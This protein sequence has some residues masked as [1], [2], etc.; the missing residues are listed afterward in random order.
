MDFSRKLPI[1]VQSFK[2]L[3]DDNFL[4]IDKTEYVY[5]LA[6]SGRVYFLS[7]PRRFG[8]SLFL[9]TLK[10]YFLGQKELFK[11]LAI[12]KF[13]EAEKGKREIWQEYPVFYFDF[14][15][16]KYADT[17]AL[18]ERLDFLL[19]DIEK[20]YEI[21]PG[22]RDSLGSRFERAIKTAYEKT[23]KQVVILVDEYDKPLLQTMGL[24]EELN[25][26]YKAVLRAFYSVLKSTDQYLRF[27]FLTGV[28]KFGKV[29]IFSDLNSLND[30][31]LKPEY[32]AICGLTQKELE[33]TFRP[34]IKTLAERNELSYEDCLS[35]LKKKYDGYCFSYG[36][37]TIY[38]PFSL[39]N[40]FDG[41]QFADYWFATGTPTFLVNELKREDYNI[42]E[43]D[44]NVEMIES[45]LSD[46]RVGAD[47]VIPVL[48]QAG[49]LTIKDYDKE[50][51]MYRLGFPNE[52]VRYGFLYNLLPEYSNI[53]FIK[54]SFNVVQFT[55]DLKAGRVDEFMQ[56][57]K[58]IM[59]SLP[60]D[61]VKKESGESIAL[62]EHNFQVC[63]Y[64]IFALMGQFVEVETPSST[65][66][67][68]CVVKTEKAIY[69]FEFKLKENA[70]A[71][72][73]QI[74][75][76]NYAERYKAD[77]KEIILIGVSFDPEEGTV[78]EWLS[79]KL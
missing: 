52:E 3:R 34:E 46:Y 20:Q 12:E 10:A 22:S 8:K 2:V 73:K 19:K 60:Y 13:E 4:Y 5:R 58:S 47:S 78:D 28:T 16:G 7:R 76:K 56:R 36:T 66:R 44:G 40:V 24:N 69:I 31:S 41:K 17:E 32:S 42:P 27:A 25:A 55:K 65:G 72:L 38:N 18:N 14:N 9:S 35:A 39:L 23:G 74:K 21:I 29:S 62:K 30:I 45:F 48:F 54:T 71:A 59:A 77:S 15:V 67:T 51:R 57:L 61:T 63:V 37:E 75:E 26:E 11:G 50:Y 49:Y 6:S 33:E 1:G 64:L 79:E 68:D 43:L 70:E 53:S